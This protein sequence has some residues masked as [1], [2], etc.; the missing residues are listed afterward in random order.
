MSVTRHPIEIVSPWSLF[1]EREAKRHA[2]LFERDYQQAYLVGELFERCYGEVVASEDEAALKKN[3][4]RWRREQM[5]RIAVRDLIGWADLDETLRDISDLADALVSAAL[6]WWYGRLC[7]KLGTPIGEESGE[8][9]KMIVLGMGK[10]GG[11]ELNFSSDIDLIFVYAENGQTDGVRAMSNDEFFVK[12]GQMM[13]KSLT[14]MTADG[15]VYRVDMRLRPFGEAGPLAISFSGMEHY[16]EVHGRAWERYALVKAR[17]MAGDVQKG[18][19]LMAILRP[20]I[21]RRYIDYTAMDSL[22]DLKRMIAAEVAKKGMQSNIKLGAGG[23]REVEF[24]VQV[25]Q[26]VHGGRDKGLQ[27]RALQPVLAYLAQQDYITQ[28]DGAELKAAYVFLRRAENRIQQWNDQQAH[29]L[30]KDA[31]QQLALAQSMGF[32]TYPAFLEELAQHRRTV[33]THFD[34][35]F[36]EE[37]PVC[38]LTDALAQAWKGPLED[39]ALV[40]LTQF[41]FQ[42]PGEVLNLLRQFKR[43]R[44]LS[45][46]SAEGQMRLEGVMPHLMKTVCSLPQAQAQALQRVLRV[47]ESVV[48]RS[49]YLVL[50]K[51]NPLALE[52]LVKLCAIGPW[53][54]DMLVKYP[55]LM[56]QLIDLRTLYRPLKKEELLH[57]AASLLATYGD[58]EEGFMLQLRHWRHAQVF[59][60]AA[61][62]MTGQVPVMHVSDYLTWIAQ[63]VLQVTHDYVW[64]LMTAKHGLPQGEAASPF[65][66]V[67]YGKLGGIELGYGSDLDMVFIYDQR[68][69]DELTQAQHVGQRVVDHATFFTRMGQKIISVLTTLMPAGTLYEVDTRLRPNGA[70]GLM[71][72]SWASFEQYQR[73]KAWTWEHQALIR[74]R[75]VV[76]SPSVC[77]HFEAFRVAFLS[78][79]RDADRVR[80]EVVDMRQK[81]RQSLDK[82]NAKTFD[83]KHGVGGIVD[84][85]FMVQYLVLAFSHQHPSLAIW[86]DNMRILDAL[87]SCG[88]LS[89]HAIE[90]LQNNYRA[91]RATYHRLALQKEKAILDAKTFRAE[92]DQ[93]AAI[94]Q[95]L[96]ASSDT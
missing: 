68:A 45:H 2:D 36:A 56:D 37:S 87:K 96:M 13:N 52:H 23:I 90:Q 22:R 11:Q 57:E 88:L 25:F 93:V 91:Y 51:E 49:V 85:E 42:Q 28:Q 89:L 3:L 53:L 30:P 40:V 95:D 78:Q 31:R 61:A 92:R 20:F 81:M 50:L 15:I 38:D 12:L 41:G 64:A 4:R 58:D 46:M 59:R 62:D 5:V 18:R 21:Y 48:R 7:E 16:Y 14:E 66:I 32:E 6:D 83:L 69:P 67:G 60:V 47:V 34:D 9:Q 71:V 77:S 76:G 29:S 43:S 17:V 86:S 33:Q 65:M 19:E 79:P 35:V 75:A 94:W 44:A 72:S 39:D 1:V 55:A 80:A 82:S 27:G 74:A 24:I 10:L 8:P 84:I 26:L 70:S 54:T 63:A 73:E